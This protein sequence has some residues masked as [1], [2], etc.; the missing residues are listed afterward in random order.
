MSEIDDNKQRSILDASSDAFLIL[1]LRITCLGLLGYWTLIL[2]R[3]FLA[4]MV[5]SVIFAV[6]FYPVF[7]WLSAMLRGRRALAAAAIVLVSLL[8][9]LGPA[10]WLALSLVDNVS[11]LVQHVADGRLAV[12]PPPESVKSWPV[13][14]EQFYGIW[15]QASSNLKALLIE[16]APQLKSIGSRLLGM[17]GN[18][19][20]NLVKFIVAVVISGFLF[21][22][23]RA[24]VI[25]TKHMLSRVATER[26]EEFIDTAGA[27]IRN[28]SR[29]VIGISLLQTLLAGVG[30]LIAGVPAAGLLSFLI[31]IL[32]I[33][34]I[35]PTIVLIPLVIWSWFTMTTA[36]AVVFTAYMLIV[37]LSDNVLR[38]LVMA[39]G[40]SAPVPVIFIGVIGGTI[41]HGLLGLFVGPIV[42][43]IAWQLIVLFT[44]DPPQTNAADPAR[45]EPTVSR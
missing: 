21:V 7:S 12:P 34:Q 27:T 39:K 29:G 45:A 22:P 19:G 30:L 41:A 16:A 6:A 5:W 20:L 15:H 38:P 4:I 11:T 2:I 24:M 36:A 37:G 1:A 23:G 42:L 33:I 25:A 40:L 18:A 3:P 9:L 10:T 8:I 14:G 44:T 43:S 13:F 17:A 32:G 31:L 26:G 35:G 28:V